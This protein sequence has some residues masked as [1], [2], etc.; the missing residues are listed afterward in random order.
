ML[1]ITRDKWKGKLAKQPAQTQAL[2][3][4]MADGGAEYCSVT[5][6]L[7]LLQYYDLHGITTHTHIYIHTSMRMYRGLT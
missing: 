6:V 2:H 3:S 4:N 7:L 1:E 5:A